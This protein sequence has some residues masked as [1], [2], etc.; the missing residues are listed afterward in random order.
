MLSPAPTP[1]ETTDISLLGRR[2]LERVFEEMQGKVFSRFDGVT[3]EQAVEADLVS[4]NYN[5][6]E[7]FVRF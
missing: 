6:Y 1:A 5:H 4:N 2:L 3:F 7:V